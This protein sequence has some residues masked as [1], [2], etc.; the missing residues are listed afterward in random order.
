VAGRRHGAGADRHRPGPD[1]GTRSTV[2]PLAGRDGVPLPL[3]ELVAL[4]RAFGDNPGAADAAAW[5]RRSAQTRAA[6]LTA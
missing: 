2:V 3:E 5:L 6:A 4:A 1:G